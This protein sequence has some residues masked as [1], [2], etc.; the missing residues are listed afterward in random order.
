MHIYQ[1][2]MTKSVTKQLQQFEPVKVEMEM[3]AT[4]TEDDK[5]AE[6]IAK[7]THAIDAAI[8]IGFRGTAGTPVPGKATKTV[9]TKSTPVNA[10]VEEPADPP[11]K[12]K[13]KRRTKEEIAADKAAAEA[14]EAAEETEADDTDMMGM[15][16]SAE[17]DDDDVPSEDVSDDVLMAATN[18]A[19]KHLK[20]AGVRKVMENFNAKRLSEMKD[21]DRPRYMMHL[22]TALKDMGVN[23]SL[24]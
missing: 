23:V 8:E 24:Q 11:A 12:P 15:D 14:A 3:H 7:M 20:P 19:V 13:R 6:C 10:T 5:Y 4:L 16:F 1:V 22:Q 21:A 17:D 2:K 18:R 9:E